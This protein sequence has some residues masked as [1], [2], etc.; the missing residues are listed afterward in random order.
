MHLVDDLIHL[1]RFMMLRKVNLDPKEE[2]HF[3]FRKRVFPK[4]SNL[5][6][7]HLLTLVKKDVEF[8]Q[9]DDEDVVRVCLL[10]ALDFVFMGQE[11]RHTEVRHEVHVR[12]EV[13]RFVD[14]EEVR[15]RAV[16]EEDVK[17]IAVFAKTVKEQEQMIV[18]LQHCLL[19]LEQITKKTKHYHASEN[20]PVGGLDH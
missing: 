16:D 17:E 9:L 14:K 8:N 20:V 13:R 3:E 7:E 18:D 2:D 11:L 4:I 6:G 1:S 19:S 12:T 15:T 10:L 5:K